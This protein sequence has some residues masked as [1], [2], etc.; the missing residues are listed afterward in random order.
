MSDICA[1]TCV[2]CC[3]IQQRNHAKKNIPHHAIVTPRCVLYDPGRQHVRYGATILPLRGV[4]SGNVFLEAAVKV[5]TTKNEHVP[6][7]PHT[8]RPRRSIVSSG[9]G[10]CDHEKKI[11][12]D[13]ND[14]ALVQTVWPHEHN[15]GGPGPQ[16][17]RVGVPLM[18][19]TDA[20]TRDR[21]QVGVCPILLSKELRCS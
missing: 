21:L 20:H 5:F 16:F 4:S 7:M 9:L 14:F 17:R 3:N 12:S 11:F 13:F 6:H 8:W 15:R 18:S 1:R 19:R 10:R 2:C